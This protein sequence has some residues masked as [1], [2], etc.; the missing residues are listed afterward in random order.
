MD[1]LTKLGQ[2]FVVGFRGLYP[3]D[4][5]IEAVRR[6]KIGNVILFKDNIESRSQLEK[7]TKM[8]DEVIFEAT[9]IHP[10]IM[11]DQEGGMVSRL[12]DD[13]AL[14]PGAMA[15]AA[16][17]DTE[18]IEECGYITARELASSGVNLDIAPVLDINTSLE[19]SILGVRS[20]GETAE[21]VIRYSLPMM[22][23]LTRGGVISCAKHFPG[24]GD[25][26]VDSHMGLPV[27]YK[28]ENELLSCELKPY[29]RAIEQGVPCIMTSHILFP[30]IDDSG[31]PATMSGR[32]INGLLRTSLAFRGVVIT[33]CLEMGAIKDHYTTQEGARKA[34]M[35]GVDIACVSHT[36]S[37]AVSSMERIMQDAGWEKMQDESFGRIMR[38]KDEYFGKNVVP[39]ENDELASFRNYVDTVGER[40]ITLYRV[41]KP[42][43]FSSD[44]LFIAPHPFVVTAIMN[45]EDRA[46]S[47]ASTMA[48]EFGGEGLEISIDPAPDEIDSVLRR[49]GR[50]RK[51][52]IG[53]YN[54]CFKRGQL[55]LVK[56]LGKIG[57]ELVVVALRNP[58][59]LK[60]APENADLVALYEYSASSMRW[61]IKAVRKNLPS[62]RRIPFLRGDR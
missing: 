36:I 15:L 50:W 30:S 20:Y 42:L 13:Y 62:T 21:E 26:S 60:Y 44:T 18:A 9:S 56:A 7:L 58:Y 32:I 54:G 23:G 59:D 2:R 53:T 10:F 12:S 6:M 43:S 45:P 55:E 39:L 49:A 4:E 41:K 16:T 31:Y 40:T 48:S 46:L 25:V 38:L 35:C 57:C 61:F 29:L 22:K 19:K 17:D 8:L 33:D 34:L 52:V 5:F 11:I 3:S 51:V 14:I 47:F 28:S 37:L 24:H 27:S 1:S